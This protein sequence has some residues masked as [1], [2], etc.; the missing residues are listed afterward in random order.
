MNIAVSRAVV[1]V[2]AGGLLIAVTYGLARYGYGFFVPTFRAEFGLDAAFIG[3]IATGSY[4]SYCVAIVAATLLLPRVG[5]RAVAAVAA[6]VA[7]VGMA[8]LAVAPNAGILASGVIF[9]GASTGLASPPVAD[10]VARTVREGVRDRAQT[11]VN[12]ATAVGVA[13][14]GPVALLVHGQWR[15]AWAGF[16]AVAAIA[17]VGVL[18]ALPPAGHR[19]VATSLRP[20]PVLRP[21]AGRLLSSALLL[22]ASSSAVWTFGR[23][24]WA[25]DDAI[26]ETSSMTAWIV[27][28]VTGVAG[29]ATGDL[30]HRW[31]RESVW[32]VFMALLGTA[33]G[34]VVIAPASVVAALTSAAAFGAGFMVLTGVLLVWG[35]EV[36]PEAPGA[37]VG[38][39]FLA[40]TIGSAVGSVLVGVLSS[41]LGVR[42][43]F[44]T[45]A[46]VALL[47]AA[48][49][50]LARR[51]RGS[52]APSRGSLPA[53][54]A[55]RRH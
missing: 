53:T 9:A 25:S 51:P 16:A 11:A 33:T 45:A 43:A 35:T 54:P 26:G 44:L 37:G 6:I 7:G 17:L 48:V 27:L 28:G 55:G 41:A 19:E 10:A 46:V 22:G 31:G 42:F 34:V 2:S 14:A 15:I 32:V 36:Y 4:L 49:P 1:V 21:G 29:A 18:M 39:G 23:D 30:V 5:A 40:L 12:A 20:R 8:A 47:G 3:L 52:V 38:L 24:V 50:W 13:V